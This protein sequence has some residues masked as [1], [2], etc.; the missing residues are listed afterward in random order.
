MTPSLRPINHLV[1]GLVLFFTITTLVYIGAYVC[2]SNNIEI[3][4][5]IDYDFQYRQ[6]LL[7]V[8]SGLKDAEIGARGYALTGKRNF[9]QPYE[10]AINALPRQILELKQTA[11]P[12][13]TKKEEV[14][15]LENKL[16]Q[17]LVLLK[18]LI[19]FKA[20]GATA[21]NLRA[22]LEEQKNAMDDI[23]SLMTE[24]D[25]TALTA[26]KSEL[27]RSRLNVQVAYALFP[28][29][30]IAAAA[31]DGSLFEGVECVSPPPSGRP[32]PSLEAYLGM[33]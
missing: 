14:L 16:S 33:R 31:D 29:L 21:E 6:Q 15:A 19:E 5:L 32:E 27:P 7:E 12:S 13:T 8:L 4:S 30:G 2:M 24:L 10:V 18:K 26:I 1:I 9:L 25:S 3:E 20:N 22:M 28:F 11:V 17:E 23:R